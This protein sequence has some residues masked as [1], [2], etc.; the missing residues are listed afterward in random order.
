MTQ[1]KFIQGLVKR[2]PDGF[3]FFIPDDRTQPDVYIP[4][5]SMLGVMTNDRVLVDVQPEKGTQRFRGEVIKIVTR[6]HKKVVGRF[7]IMNDKMASIQ[8]ESHSWGSDLYVKIE[9]SMNAEEGELVAAEITTYPSENEKFI[10]KVIERIGSTLDPINDI[11]RVIF[12]NNIPFEFSEATQREALQFAPEVQES[13][14]KNRKDLRGLS[15][16]TIDGTTAKDFDDAVYVETNPQG[17]HLYVAIADVSHYVQIGSAID[18]DA[19]ERGTSVYFPNFVVPM[20]PEVLSNELCSLKP[21]VARLCLVAEMQIDFNGVVQ[22]AQFYEAVM[23]SK[24]RVTYGEAQEVIDGNDIEKLRHVKDNILRCADLAKLLMA[25][26]FREGSLD[27][28]L[29]ETQLQIDASGIPVDVTKTE[30]LFAHRLIEELMLIANVETAKFLSKRD[31][32]AL[33]RIHEEPRAEALQ[34]LEKYLHNFGAKTRLTGGGLQKK[35]TKALEEFHGKPEAQVL[36][37]LTLRS[38]AQAK[39]SSQNVGHFG[40]GFEFYTHFTSPIRRYPDLIV[41]R[42]LKNQVMPQSRYRLIPEDEISTAGNMLSAC[43]QRSV[44]AERQLMSIKKARF[45]EKYIGHEFEGIVSSVAKFGVFVLLR[46]FD[47][48]GL[49]R[50]E[51]LGNDRFE[52]DEDNLILIGQRTRQ[53]YTLGDAVKIIVA[54]SNHGNGQIDFTLADNVL[55][56]PKE[57]KEFEKTNSFRNQNF[58]RNNKK[59]KKT[60]RRDKDANKKPNKDRPEKR[61]FFGKNKK[62]ENKKDRRDHDQKDSYKDKGQSQTRSAPKKSGA[63][64]LADIIDRAQG[65]IKELSDEF[66]KNKSADRKDAQKRGPSEDDRRGVRKAR[67]SQRRGKNKAR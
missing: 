52:F 58:S 61:G 1:K 2:H 62:Q 22:S 41:H 43:E 18:R 64:S 38:M 44:K 65:K 39:Y 28:E 33:Y 31:I 56:S 35:L 15:L 14:F 53:V 60:F 50:L 27:L 9:D 13:D 34:V 49:I 11:K 25:K 5:H 48:D 10:G 8:D 29:P 46:E 51:E 57:V 3:G 24:A 45:M 54:Q 19:Y 12:S 36:N 6:F 23:Q 47:I 55:K 4:K 20:L 59:D 21:H 17:F 67:F 37:I 66:I 26:R 32:P 7:H 40:L 30:R 16:I 42:L 63:R